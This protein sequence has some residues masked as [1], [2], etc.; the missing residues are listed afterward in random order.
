MTAHVNDVPW[1]VT[2]RFLRPGDNALYQQTNRAL[3]ASANILCKVYRC[4]R[5]LTNRR[6]RS[7]DERREPFLISVLSIL[8]YRHPQRS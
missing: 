8:M 1:P 6:P 5:S 2:L 7:E 3:L 4:F